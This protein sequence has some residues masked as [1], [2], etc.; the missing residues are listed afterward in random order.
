MKINS[1]SK[2]IHNNFNKPLTSTI[3]LLISFIMMSGLGAATDF[4]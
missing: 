1:I 3:I 2:N 4:T